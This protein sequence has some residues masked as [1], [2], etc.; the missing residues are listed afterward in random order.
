MRQFHPP[1]ATATL[2][3]FFSFRVLLRMRPGLPLPFM[4]FRP[5]QGSS[6]LTDDPAVC[7]VVPP[8]LDFLPCDADSHFENAEHSRLLFS[9]RL[10]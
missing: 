6:A 7:T 10:R 4:G 2:L 1:H 5:L 8:L 3:A 9:F